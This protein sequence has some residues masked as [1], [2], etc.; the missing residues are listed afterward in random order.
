MGLKHV[1]SG[2]LENLCIGSETHKLLRL[3]AARSATE[4]RGKIVAKRD[5]PM[6]VSQENLPGGRH[7]R[8][9]PVATI[10]SQRFLDPLDRFFGVIK[11][12][13]LLVFDHRNCYFL[14]IVFW[15]H[16]NQAV[17][18]LLRKSRF[19]N[20]LRLMLCK[21]F[22]STIHKLTYSTTGY[23]MNSG[24]RHSIWYW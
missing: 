11:L 22:R 17:Y 14:M 15:Y 24:A 9:R 8:R 18:D 13:S 2:W 6:P 5:L 7:G 4:H 1:R 19:I 23:T 16:F 20:K 12:Q 10:G 21:S 3:L